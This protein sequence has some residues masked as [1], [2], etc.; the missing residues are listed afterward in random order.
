MSDYSIRGP[1]APSISPGFYGWNGRGESSST[2][3]NILD[4]KEKSHMCS[5]WLNHDNKTC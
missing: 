1:L 4:W 5:R 3:D 2:N